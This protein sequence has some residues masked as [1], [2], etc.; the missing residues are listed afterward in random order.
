[1]LLPFS[2]HRALHFALT[3]LSTCAL[4][5]ACSGP[6]RRFD[7]GAAGSQAGSAG[8]D[9]GGTGAGGQKPGTSGGVRNEAGAAG[10]AGSSDEEGGQSGE[11]GASEVSG[12]GGQGQSAGTGGTAAS[13]G[14]GGGPS[15]GGTSGAGGASQL[16]TPQ[17]YRCNGAVSEQC[18]TDGSKYTAARTCGAVGCNVANGQCNQCNP[19]QSQCG[20]SEYCES[21]SCATSGYCVTRPSATSVT[22]DPQCGCD[23]VAYW[24]AVH[25]HWLGK[26]VIKGASKAGTCSSPK[27]CS[28]T[29]GCGPN[30][31]CI[32]YYQDYY[33][34]SSP[35]YGFCMAKPST[36]TSAA[37]AGQMA[38]GDGEQ[39]CGGTCTSFCAA[40]LYGKVTSA[41]NCGA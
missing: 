10:S 37:C 19:T 17:S 32:I 1:M 29:A 27:Q 20:A 30:E 38:S 33:C 26:T 35:S 21:T 6:D 34:S 23:G 15:A 24:N 31:T 16:C 3:L 25:A 4:F 41:E 13:S 2:R 9:R 22:F 5:A 14:Q 8:S 18:S 36:V 11:A 28:S 7:T 40:W 39:E 12:N